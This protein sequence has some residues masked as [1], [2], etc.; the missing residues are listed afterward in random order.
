MGTW[1]NQAAE[2]RQLRDQVRRQ[3]WTIEKLKKYLPAEDSA[4]FPA[5][6]DRERALAAKGKR[7]EAIQAYRTRTRSDLL[8]AKIAIESVI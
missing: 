1:F 5:V 6:N 3:A 8:T 4:L 7:L 2:I